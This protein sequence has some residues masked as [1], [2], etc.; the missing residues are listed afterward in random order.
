MG[1]HGHVELHFCMG[2]Q[3]L[4]RYAFVLYLERFENVEAWPQSSTA[5]F[6]SLELIPFL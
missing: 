1:T 6:L 3:K 2:Y 4:S 5:S